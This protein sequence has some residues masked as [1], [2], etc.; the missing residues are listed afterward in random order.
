MGMAE[1]RTTWRDIAGELRQAIAGGK[2][3]PGSRLPSRSELMARYGV[4]PQT[5]VNAI[6]ALRQEGLVRGV[7]GSGWYVQER[8]RVIRSSRSRLSPEERAAG[9]GA[10]I[11]DAHAGGWNPRS[12]TQVRVEPADIEVAEALGIELG[13]E[14]LVRDRV[15]YADDEPLQLA[16]SYLPRELT[17]GTPI[18][19]QNPGPGG[20]YARLEEAGHS[21]LTFDEYVR[22]GR[23]GEHEAEQLRIPAGTPVFRITRI[24]SHGRQIVEINYIMLIGERFELFYTAG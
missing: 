6:N 24:A 22:I 7:P 3:G 19:E 10:F 5:V 16:I 9:R 15:M 23:A 11:T 20:I 13:S 17:R 12:Q 21:P 2:Y 4:A 1:G 14:V 18:E 8:P